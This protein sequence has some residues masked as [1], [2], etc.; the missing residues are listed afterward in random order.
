MCIITVKIKIYGFAFTQHNGFGLLCSCIIHSVQK[1]G[2]IIYLIFCFTLSAY[3]RGNHFIKGFVASIVFLIQRKSFYFRKL[4]IWH[5]FVV[6]A[7]AFLWGKH[8]VIVFII[9]LPSSMSSK[10]VAVYFEKLGTC[11]IISLLHVPANFKGTNF[12]EVLLKN[13]CL[14]LMQRR[15]FYITFLNVRGIK[16]RY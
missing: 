8:S 3:F 2:K 10:E 14:F 9:F 13:F 15:S 7:W 5:M 16:M 4:S 11:H 12:Q 6:L 1:T